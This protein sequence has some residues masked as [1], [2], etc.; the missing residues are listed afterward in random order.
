MGR[1]IML[2]NDEIEGI[3]YSNKTG[4]IFEAIKDGFGFVIT[5]YCDTLSPEFGPCVEESIF[6]I[7]Y[8][9][10]IYETVINYSHEEI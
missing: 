4:R 9:L 1:P 3:Y 2:K 8:A 7:Q 5:R 10:D 6:K